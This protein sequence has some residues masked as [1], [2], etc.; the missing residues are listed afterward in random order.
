MIYEAYLAGLIFLV[1]QHVMGLL[2]PGPCT[3]LVIRNS[4]YSRIQGLRTVAGAT[5]GSFSIK[6][7]SVLGLA[8]LLMHSPHLFQAFKVAGGAFLIFLGG[9]SL[10]RAYGE[11]YMGSNGLK[12]TEM[13]KVQGTPFI[14]GY[15]MSI[16]NPMSSVRFIALFATAI[17]VEMPLLLQLSYLVV[18]AI[19]SFT[20]YLCMALFFST[21]TIQKKMANYRYILS[22]ILGCTLIYWGIKILQISFT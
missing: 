20:F 19:I 11:F 16:A 12:T 9:Q 18:L 6:T 14:S 22:A 5:L 10:W 13:E 7:L 3:A 15:L 8:L 21:T 17:T 2:A 1:T 4:I